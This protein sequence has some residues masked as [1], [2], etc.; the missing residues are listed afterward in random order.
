MN[1]KTEEFKS[2][3]D[4]QKAYSQNELLK[5]TIKEREEMIRDYKHKNDNLKDTV[6]RLIK[7]NKNLQKLC[8]CIL[9]DNEELEKLGD[10]I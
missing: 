6:K 8:D 7:N 3:I 1:N 10:L 5:R 4:L 9:K 2:V